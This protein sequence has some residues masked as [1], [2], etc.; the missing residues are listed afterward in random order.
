MQVYM[1]L[2]CSICDLFLGMFDGRPG[3]YFFMLLFNWACCVIV[4]LIADIPV[5]VTSHNVFDTNLTLDLL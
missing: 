5:S 4:G 1:K 2:I 3:D